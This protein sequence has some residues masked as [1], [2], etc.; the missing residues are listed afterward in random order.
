MRYYDVAMHNTKT[1]DVVW[2]FSYDIIVFKMYNCLSHIVT[3]CYDVTMQHTKA[4][5]TVA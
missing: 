2:T 4:D 5:D 3:R 1:D